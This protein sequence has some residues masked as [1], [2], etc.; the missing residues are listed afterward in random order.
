MSYDL[1]LEFRLERVERKLKRIE[2]ILKG[3]GIEI[4]EEI[5]Q[6]ITDGD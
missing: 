5:K 6:Y 2:Q 3:N 4:D 1:N